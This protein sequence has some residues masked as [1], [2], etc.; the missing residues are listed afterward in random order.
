MI[1]KIELN[2]D[3]KAI[4]LNALA[5]HYTTLTE[6]SIFRT[7]LKDLISLIEESERIEVE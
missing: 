6:D 5:K 3:D 7:Q 1:G 2:I 4:M